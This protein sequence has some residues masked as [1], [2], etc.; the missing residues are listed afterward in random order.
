MALTTN[1]SMNVI[2]TLTGALDLGS[3]VA[4]QTLPWS[5]TWTDGTGSG[6]ADLTWTD[7]RQIAISGTDDLDLAA[8]GLVSALGVT[9][10]FARVKL[11][12]VTADAGN[13]N[14]V[15]VGGAASNQFVGPFGAATQTHAIKPG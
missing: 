9:L 1:I 6:Q 5:N 2:A 14:N 10:T 3:V 4:P 11:I 12:V 15:V 7:T 13:T 8:G